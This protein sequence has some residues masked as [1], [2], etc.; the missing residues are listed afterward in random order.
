MP[1]SFAGVNVPLRLDDRILE[2]ADELMLGNLR[3]VGL[4]RLI[5][6]STFRV[7]E[8]PI[9]NERD[10]CAISAFGKASIQACCSPNPTCK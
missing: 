6:A 2:T 10:Q 8:E 4:L 7:N 1:G 3:R 9:G 5:P